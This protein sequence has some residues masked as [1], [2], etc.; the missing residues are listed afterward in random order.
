MTV[1]AEG[2]LFPLGVAAV[3]GSLSRLL[4]RFREWFKVCDR[5]FNSLSILALLNLNLN[6]RLCSVLLARGRDRDRV[7]ERW[8]IR[9]RR[10]RV[11]DTMLRN[12]D[13]LW[14]I[15]NMGS[16]Q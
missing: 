2:S 8:T 16:S 3:T 14:Y 13:G 4:E 6:L 10:Y 1:L 9:V 15:C 5:Y 11:I 12:R 7:S